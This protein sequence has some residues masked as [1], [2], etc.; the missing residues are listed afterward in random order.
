MVENKADTDREWA[1]G[2]IEKYKA[3]FPRYQALSQTLQ[4]VFGEAAKR[5][6]P[7]AIVQTRP[8]SFTSF[9][10]K[11]Q[12]KKGKYRDPLMRMTDLCGG[13]V[14]T[15]TQSE[16]K[17]ICEFLEHYFEI[18][19]ANSIDVSQR[20][21]PTEFGYRS[22]HYIVQVKRNAFPFKGVEINIPE[23]LFP[24]K[25][26]PMKAEIQVRTFLEHA[27]ADFTHDLSYKSEFTIPAKWQREMAVVAGML[28]AADH[29]FSR[30]QEGLRA[31]A[32]NYGAYMSKEGIREEMEILDTVLACDPDNPQM[33]HRIGKLAM[34]L[35][36]W[37]KAIEVFRKFLDSDYP[38]ILRDLGIAL[39][40]T[41]SMNPSGPLYREGQK[42]LGRAC[43]AANNDAD[44]LASL[45]GTWKSIDE[46][47]TR[48]LYRRAFEMDPSDPYALSNYLVYEIVVRKDLEPAVL[49]TP[50]IN[51][52]IERSEAQAEVGTNLPWAFYNV[53]I[54]HLLLGKPYESLTAY[55]KAIQASTDAWMIETSL[56]LLEKLDLLQKEI[57]GLDWIR[58]LL[59]AGW[60]IRFPNDDIA[61]RIIPMALNG[62]RPISGPVVI[63]AGSCDSDSEEQIRE[64]RQILAEGFRDYRGTVI[65]GGT[66]AGISGLIGDMQQMY[67]QAI[68]T[69]GYVPDVLPE[70]VSI[71]KRYREIRRTDGKEFSAAEPMQYWIDL[72]ASDI[73]PGEIRVLGIQGGIISTAEYR[74]ALALGSEVGILGGEEQE[75]NQL[76]RESNQYILGKILFL[77]EDPM[78]VRAFIGSGRVHLEAI[79]REMLA[80]AIHEAYREKQSQIEQGENP[81]MAAWD[82]LEDYLK[83]S[84]RLQ[85]DH[86]V[87]KMEQIGCRIQTAEGPLPSRPEFS[88][89]EVEKLAEMEHGR[90]IVERLENGW[91]WGEKRD[92]LKKISP[93]LVP[94]AQLPDSVKEWDRETIRTIPEFLAKIGME[95]RR[96]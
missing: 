95:I 39:C 10:E 90:W 54:F 91:I 7:L 83:D 5:Y 69:I 25:D 85:A 89:L 80:K 71:D 63:V 59:L 11:I 70:G 50:I 60:K 34:A 23:E 65:S 58:R 44:A 88:K 75:V 29:S 72:I 87:E 31:Y 43:A 67:P 51:A 20:L 56:R 2:Q 52:S 49:L 24:D 42:F 15:H 12:R 18:D 14:I 30:V 1:C 47:R 41:N 77:P 94:W 55:T 48:E 93:F 36:D 6:A 8:K 53:G 35:G 78:T 76:L 26:C 66:T 19:W 81:S 33:A 38:P 40:K 4:L 68:H 32:S 13:R 28:E 96:K 62:K 16:V 84:N 27:W 79:P 46:N 21:K 9:A 57:I 3:V 82:H 61:N 64:Y 86:I 17:A 92:I 73:L 37:Q 74:I 22:V 45:A